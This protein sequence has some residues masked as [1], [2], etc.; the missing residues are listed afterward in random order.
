MRA[1]FQRF[2]KLAIL[3][4]ALATALAAAPAR[5]DHYESS[6]T[7]THSIQAPFERASESTA[8]RNESLAI[9]LRTRP[10]ASTS[11]AIIARFLIHC[12]LLL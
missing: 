7:S 12:A 6:A 2:R 10:R 1:S 3:F 9:T 11:H 5:A 8:P 4:A